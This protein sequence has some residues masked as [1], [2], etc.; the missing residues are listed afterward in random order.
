M[1]PLLLCA[2]A[3][4]AAV[5]AAQPATAELRFA[6][7]F[8]V[9]VGRYGLEPTQKLLDL[10]GKTVRL[11][12][13]MVRQEEPTPGVLV[14]AAYRLVM[15]EKADGAA[16]DLPPAIA[17][18]H[19][20]AAGAARLVPY[21]PQLLTV[22][23]RL[24]VGAEDEADGRVSWVRLFATDTILPATTASTNGAAP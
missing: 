1:Y 3:L 22:E 5:P 6:E 13:Y 24:S 18:I 21:T 15:S 23:G 16:D 14:L 8:K 7:F 11:R 10:N 17:F 4:T 9:P 20:P 19:L 2:L 12:G